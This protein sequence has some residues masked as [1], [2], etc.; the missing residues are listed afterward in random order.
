MISSWYSDL[1]LPENLLLPGMAAFCFHGCLAVLS[2][3]YEKEHEL[4]YGFPE[5]GAV[6]IP[7]LIQSNLLSKY[8][9]GHT[10]SVLRVRGACY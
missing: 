2:V 5:S 1:S 8:L 7:V 9:E 6:A 3:V 10:K 4:A